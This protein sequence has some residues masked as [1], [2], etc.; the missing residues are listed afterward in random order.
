MLNLIFSF[1]YTSFQSCDL[2]LLS[3]NEYLM[4]C[5]YG[6]THC[7]YYRLGIHKACHCI[8]KIKFDSTLPLKAY[9]YFVCLF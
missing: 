7:M 6:R 9:C 3:F 8:I 5:Y 4:N 2:M 1:Q